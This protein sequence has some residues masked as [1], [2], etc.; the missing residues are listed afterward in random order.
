M[1]PA[2]PS[3]VA[4]VNEAGFAIA[5]AAANEKFLDE[6]LSAVQ[7]LSAA[8]GGEITYGLRGL[9]ARS[10]R[11][12]ALAMQPAL[13]DLARAVL[14][15]PA[16]VVKG[17]YFDKNPSAN[18]L[19]PWHQDLTI[20][21]RERREAPGFG[22][23]SVKD[24]LPHVQPPTEIM[25]NIIALRVHL[26]DAGADNGALR[27]LPGT[28]QRG[29]IPGAEIPRLAR[30]ITPVI[31]AAKRGDVLIMRPLLLHSSPICAAPR[32]RRVIHLEYTTADLPGGLEWCG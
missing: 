8:T 18:W 13:L 20:T 24:G 11:C 16:R 31:C 12:R 7:D 17:I 14:G 30:E 3:L 29:R 9:L 23:W 1:H 25:E 10:E 5:H 21:V 26:D 27:V 15:P 19:V 32:H 4:E 22:P 2:P 6:W 28:H